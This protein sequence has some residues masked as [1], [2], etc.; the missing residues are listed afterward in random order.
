[1][2]IL[3]V[4]SGNT[5]EGI[6]PI[7][8][9][10]GISL[11]DIGHDIS[12]FTIK[13]KGIK[14]YLKHVFILRNYLKNGSFDIVHAH[15][16]LSAFTASLA[17]AKPLVVSLMGSD[18]KASPVL[19]YIIKVFKMVFWKKVIVKSEDMKVSVKLSNVNVVPNGVDFAKFRPIPR[20]DALQVTGWNPQKKHVLF[21]AN[22][23]RREKNYPL[24]EKAFNA[25]DSTIGTELH[26]LTDI[27]NNLMPTY[28]NAANVVVLTSLWEGS[29]NVIKEA[30]ACNCKIVA[31]DVGDI[32]QVIGNTDGCFIADSNVQDVSKKLKKALAMDEKT[33]GR[34]DI[35][36][37]DSALIAKKL[38][39]IYNTIA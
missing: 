24:A 28:F 17:G 32:K 16:S 37:L 3:F 15:Y 35:S 14:G 5:K 26:T 25:M 29:P 13:E 21:A 9:N 1:M 34:T 4:S 36:H 18:V 30:M 10:Q 11:Q 6:S 7:V 20:T 27:P 8:H 12:F 33:T 31:V 22:P 19:K 39:T 2:N 23:K 38:D